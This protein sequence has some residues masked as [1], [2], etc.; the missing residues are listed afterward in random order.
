MRIEELKHV[1][2]MSFKEPA[3]NEDFEYVVVDG[4]LANMGNRNR[5]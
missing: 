5:V 2:K 1:Y 3:E 4:R